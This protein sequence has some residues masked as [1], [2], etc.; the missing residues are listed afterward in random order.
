MDRFP[1][2]FFKLQPQTLWEKNR[3]GE[4]H[5]FWGKGEKGSLLEKGVS[6][7]VEEC[8]RVPERKEKEGPL[9]CLRPTPREKVDLGPQ[10]EDLQGPYK[11][12]CQKGI[13]KREGKG[14]APLDLTVG[15]K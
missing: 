3:F 9:W 4:N 14:R 12:L 6:K 8:R 13:P 11:R 10:R 1:P 5:P 15:R 7:S 2:F